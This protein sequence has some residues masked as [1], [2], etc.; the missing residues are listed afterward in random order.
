[1]SSISNLSS[2]NNMDDMA[3]FSSWTVLAVDDEPDSLELICTVLEMYGAEVTPA[4]NG[5]AALKCLQTLRPTLIFTDL[6][7][8]S[9]DGYQLLRRLRQIDGLQDTPVIALTAH[10][11]KGDREIIM[12]AGFS[13]YITKPLRLDSFIS[14]LFENVPSLRAKTNL[15]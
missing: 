12:G 9:V 8:P 13:G 11:M 10:A 5:E 15:A 14:K 4:E 2:A 3:D 7:M 1:M 6:S